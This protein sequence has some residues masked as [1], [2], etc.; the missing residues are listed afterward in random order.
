M[1]FD[2]VHEFTQPAAEVWEKLTDAR[3][4]APCLPDLDSV[5]E[6]DADRAVCVVKPNFSFAR[7]TLNMT[8]NIGDKVPAKSAKMV[9]D[10]KGIGA[11]STVEASFVLEPREGGGCV[12]KWSAAV[13]QLGGLLRALPSGLVQ[14]SAKKILDQAWTNFQAKLSAGGPS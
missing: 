2:G 4:L 3:Y 13:T 5:K 1:K 8:M 14:G 9:L 12:M 11:N 7:G 6:A 10:S